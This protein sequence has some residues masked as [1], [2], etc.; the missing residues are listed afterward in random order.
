M[1]ESTEG[2]KQPPHTTE[3]TDL[4]EPYSKAELVLLLIPAPKLRD[5]IFNLRTCIL[6]IIR[7]GNK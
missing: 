3:P 5:R 7:R 1:T 2:L 6:N 4:P